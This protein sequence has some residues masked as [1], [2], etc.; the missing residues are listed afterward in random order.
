LAYLEATTLNVIAA[1]ILVL[2]TGTLFAGERLWAAPSAE[3]LLRQGRVDE[4]GAVLNQESSDSNKH[5]LLCRVFYAQDMAEA[6]VRECEAAAARDA[7]NSDLQM[8][9]GRAYGMEAMQAN[10][11]SAFADA[12]KVRTAFERSVQLNPSNAAAMSALGQFYVQAPAIVGGGVDKAQALAPKLLVLSAAK[13]HRLLGLIAEKKNDVSHAETEY[14]SAVAAGGAPEAWIDLAYFYQRHGQTDKAAAALDSC[15]KADQA[16]SAALVDA[17]AILTQM[18]R[19][20]DLAER[21]L[22]EYLA[23]GAKSEDAPAFKVHIQLGNLLD[24]RGD[25]AG[26]RQEYA[27]ALALASKYVPARKALAGM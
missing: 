18:R 9:L 2:L 16:K 8:W 6:A 17:A 25:R 23:S 4:A 12:R 26:A 5:L 22:R 21:L 20:P 7:N 3:L 15:I 14:R 19:S 24:G 27:A 1:I 13:G 11:L 10:P